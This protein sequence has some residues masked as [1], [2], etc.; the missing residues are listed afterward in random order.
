MQ[1]HSPSR[2]QWRGGRGEREDGGGGGGVG[3]SDPSLWRVNYS[4]NRSCC[5]SLKYVGVEGEGGMVGGN[6]G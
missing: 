1:Y 2:L 6:V 3:A 5:L 4:L